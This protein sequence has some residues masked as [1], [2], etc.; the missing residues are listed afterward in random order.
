MDG[1][2]LMPHPHIYTEPLPK[3]LRCLESQLC[4]IGDD[5]ADIIGQ[6]AVGVRDIPRALKDNDLRLLIQPADSR[7]RSG[8]ACH[9]AYNHNLHFSTPPFRGIG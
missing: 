9:T 1:N 7:R 6:A 8:S 4:L 3:A 5:A 2:H